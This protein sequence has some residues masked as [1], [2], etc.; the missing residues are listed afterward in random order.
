MASIFA[1]SSARAWRSAI[2]RSLNAS[3]ATRSAPSLSRSLRDFGVRLVEVL[4]LLAQRLEILRGSGVSESIWHDGPLGRARPPRRAARAASRA[5]AASSSRS[6][7]CAKSE[8]NRLRQT[9]DLLGERDE[10]L[11]LGGERFHP[12][13]RRPPPNPEAPG[14]ARRTPRTPSC[15]P[16]ACRLRRGATRAARTNRAAVLVVSRC[17]S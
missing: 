15:G 7:D 13:F 5:R 16:A 1:S 17:T 11:V 8:S 3:S 10:V 2:I 14:R 6:S 4:N 12:A 9:V